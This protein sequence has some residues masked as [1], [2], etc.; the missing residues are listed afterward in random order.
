MCVLFVCVCVVCVCVCV[1][2]VCVDEL[3]TDVLTLDHY[4]TSR[5]QF[6]TNLLVTCKLNRCVCVV[7]CLCVR[8]CVQAEELCHPYYPDNV[9]V[10]VR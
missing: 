7:W 3:L 4:G 2:G 9:L 8:A 1:L 10:F 6:S 5:L